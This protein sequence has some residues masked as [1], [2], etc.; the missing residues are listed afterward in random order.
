MLEI[1]PTRFHAGT[2]TDMTDEMK[3]ITGGCLCG[4]IRYETT[5]PPH[6]VGYCHC[7]MCQKG[8]GNLF[9]T[10]ACFRTAY[11]RYLAEEPN[12][13]IRD[14]WIKRGFCG[15]CGSPIA[16]QKPDNDWIAIWIGSLDDRETYQPQQHGNCDN[17]ISWVD[18]QP[19]LPYRYESGELQSEADRHA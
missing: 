18:I 16:Y 5:K 12:W 3:L 19:H 7:T 6:Y 8:L 13:Y 2:E 17:R 11:F 9:G 1:N 10:Y 15:I 4:A 14:D